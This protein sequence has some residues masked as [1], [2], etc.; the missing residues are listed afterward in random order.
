MYPDSLIAR[1]YGIYK[2]D[3]EMQDPVY[4]ILMGN[5]KRIDNKYIRKIYDL[6]G[7]MVKREVKEKKVPAGIKNRPF[8]STFKNTECLKDINLLNFVKQEMVLK[9]SKT[10]LSQIV[11]K[12]RRDAVLLQEFNLMDYSMLFVIAFN[13]NYVREYPEKFECDH[14]GNL[15]EPY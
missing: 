4:L 7:S 14:K 13:P 5:T 6:K 9:F 3:N 10:D 11:V 1:I 12:L 8:E 2:V 15:I